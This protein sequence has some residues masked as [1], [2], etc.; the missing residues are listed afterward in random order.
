NWS[1]T[2]ATA[3]TGDLFRINMGANGD[4]PNIINI[5]DNGTSL[6]SVS[7]T[8]STSAIPQ[9]FTAAGDVGIAYDLAFTNQT[10]SYIK[11]NAPLYIEAGESFDSNDLTLRTYNSGQVVFDTPSGAALYLSSTSTTA[12][13]KYGFNST[14]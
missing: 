2:A 13:T 7:E 14:I 11:S 8:Q 1:P 3:L 12:D 9:Q 6:L 5:T 10:A 4:A